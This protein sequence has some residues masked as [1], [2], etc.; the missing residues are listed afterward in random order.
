MKVRR[1]IVL[2]TVIAIIINLFSP[3]S[4]LFN[5]TVYAAATGTIE[6]KPVVFKNYSVTDDGGNR[7]LKLQIG[8]ASHEIINGLDLKFSIDQTKLVP[9]DLEF[10]EESSDIDYITETPN[11][12][13]A[14]STFQIKSYS[15]GVF[16]FT[17]TEPAG[18]TALEQTNYKVGSSRYDDVNVGGEGFDYYYPI[19]SINLKVLDDSVADDSIPIS[20]FTLENVTGSLPTR[21]KNSLYGFNW[22][23]Q[24]K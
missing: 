20:W 17:T 15:N 13:I 5:H 11:S 3:Y 19:I 4:V 24:T 7:I 14:K 16:A 18:G 23:K 8:I 21:N 12:R 1:K 6:E 2:I 9:W 22:H 10:G